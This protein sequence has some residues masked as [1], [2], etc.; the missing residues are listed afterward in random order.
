MSGPSR[1][2][3]LKALGVVGVG[4]GL[5]YGT[6]SVSPSSDTDASEAT[7]TRTATATAAATTTAS[8][9]ATAT[10]PTTRTTTRTATET[11]TPT[12]S[13]WRLEPAGRSSLASI[14]VGFAE[15]TVRADGRYAAV[16]TW[17]A[18]TG[19]YLVDLNDPS[20]PEPVHHLPAGDG[21]TSLDVTFGPFDGLYC[22]TTHPAG[23]TG[24][25]IVDYGFAEG[26]PASPT[27]IGTLDAGTTHNLHVRPDEATVYT[28][29]YGDD[30]NENGVDVWTVADPRSPYERGSIGP[31]GTVHDVV[32]D[33]ERQFLHCAYMG[34]QNGGYVI[35]DV[36]DPPGATEVGRF[37]YAEH[38]GYADN[39]VGEEGFENCHYA[40]PDPRRDL[41]VVGDERSYGVPG[42][43]HV[44]DIGWGDGSPANPI[45]VGFTVSPNAEWMNSDGD[46]RDDETERFDWTG[47]QFDIVPLPDATLLVSG[48]WHEGTVLYDITDPTNPQP[49]DTHRTDAT[50]VERPSERLAAFGD[51]PMA[52]S[53]DYCRSR[54]FALTSDLLTGLYTYRIEGVAEPERSGDTETGAATDAG[55]QSTTATTADRG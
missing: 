46:G 19:S 42:G 25:E 50:R 36:S 55:T 20:A 30:P 3:V 52:Y 48:D 28:V 53:S 43:K 34:E 21:V 15:G 32:Y 41:V 4:S 23:G 35:L 18:G 39:A 26:A 24:V 16:G 6:Y 49:I 12:P 11:P 22:R 17:F 13:T 37:D 33:P 29:N 47:H 10:E 8:P 51:P 9:T 27:V 1:R 38:D 5:V 31:P 14:G 45:P 2:A 54:G 44:F 40:L 7:E